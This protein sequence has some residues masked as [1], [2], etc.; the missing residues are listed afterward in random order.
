MKHS[1]EIGTKVRVAGMEH[2][3]FCEIA[4]YPDKTGLL[5][6]DFYRSPIQS[7]R[8]EATRVVREPVP[9][10]TRCF[11]PVDSGFRCG[12]I[13]GMVDNPTGGMAMYHLALPN[14]RLARTLPENAFHVRSL[15]G[16][17]DPVETL[18]AL[19]HETPFWFE[20]RQAFIKVY[21]RFAHVSRG[22]HA[23]NGASVEL[24]P[25]QA[26]AV[27]RVL[28]DPCI[29]YLLADE[30][31][32]GKTIEAGAI[33]SQ[34]ERDVPTLRS[35][36][37]VQPAL[38]A[39]WEWELKQ[40]FHLKNVRIEYHSNI[41]RVASDTFDIIVIDEAHRIIDLCGTDKISRL[42]QLR[43]LCASSP[44]LLLLSA[45]PLLHRD[46]EVQTLLHL[47]D[48]DQ[49]RLGDLEG[50]RRRV[51][52]RGVIG[53][54]LL[55][56]ERSVSPVLLRRQLLL[57]QK[58]LADD[59]EVQMLLG[60]MPDTTGPEHAATWQCLATRARLLVAETW[61]IH[62]RMIRTRRSAL[63]EEGELRRLR[64]VD[65]PEY[66][67]AYTDDAEAYT[68]LWK[69]VDELRVAAAARVDG[70]PPETAI[71]LRDDYL[72]L[73]TA[74][75]GPV[76]RLRKLVRTLRDLPRWD[77]GRDLMQP[78]LG[79]ID[80]IPESARLEA[81]DALLGDPPEQESR[82]VV[83]CHDEEDAHK[84]AAH[85][86]RT[87]DKM[88]VL[89]LV[90]STALTAG[91]Q[92]EAF[93]G[94]PGPVVLVVDSV[95]EEGLNLQMADAVILLDLP[96]QPMRLEQRIGRL[97]RLNRRRLLRGVAIL[98][99]DDSDEDR[100]A[101]DRG[102][103]EVLVHGLGLF[104]ESLADV[105]FLLEM[106]LE[107]L[108]NLV[109]HRGP[110]ALYE[111]VD[112]LRSEF[113]EERKR[114]EE[115]A[116]IDGTAIAEVRD[117][118]WWKELE[119]TDADETELATAFTRYVKW[120]LGLYP[121]SVSEV[122]TEFPPSLFRLRPDRNHEVLVPIDR[123]QPLS[124]YLPHVATFSRKLAVQ[125]PDVHLLRPGSK[126]LDEIRELTDW[127]DRGRAFALWRRAPDCPEPQVVARVCITADLDP[128][129]SAQAGAFDPAGQA[130]LRRLTANWFAPWQ[131]ERFLLI[132]GEPA[133]PV[134]IARC[135]LS[136]D[137]RVDEN[138]SNERVPLLLSA[139]G[140]ADFPNLCRQWSQQALAEVRRSRELHRRLAEGRSDA[141]AWFA[142]RETRLL[143][144][145]SR[146]GAASVSQER[147]LLTQ[148]RTAVDALLSEPRL[149]I[150]ALGVYVL[151]AE[152]LGAPP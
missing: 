134:L 119:D 39:Q 31:G 122:R 85:L 144:N 141:E 108:T 137:R 76:D 43:Q 151:S 65:T 35:L 33:L 88:R 57:L 25:H 68:S 145:A 30:V 121:E 102:W 36:I 29:R 124:E 103:Y 15:L 23:L 96:F 18:A 13:V 135:C 45:T 89:A 97:D 138:L 142:Q 11:L 16:S 149:R 60:E 72:R 64:G 46:T 48:P 139:V 146:N 129:A 62:R 75:S 73:A 140:S 28:L 22:L 111:Q 5:S 93:A 21:D 14:E 110:A 58:E 152:R 6:V 82:W 40:R 133:D 147:H 44:H 66:A 20:H 1:F 81:L 106:Q 51:A 94:C 100:R 4:T 115:Q 9:L 107:R 114:G 113:A 116:I 98:S 105:P 90:Q 101:F 104:V 128:A 50:F 126:L 24:F 80:A 37:L 26:E 112:I 148:L 32:L 79:A 53:K 120:M 95:A 74:A 69:W 99:V 63:L 78:L 92:I 59:A 38:R 2:F 109:F 12:R 86:G 70:L 10:Q 131:V 118:A 17:A 41:D 8:V 143:L 3:G 52:R 54:L 34:L 7:E 150:D 87:Q 127:D 117:A 125:R 55:A 47:L 77:F 136:Y 84:V 71:A 42:T 49:Y 132:D 61:R 91:A 19:G 123:L 130:A 27:R 83:F 56:L 67:E